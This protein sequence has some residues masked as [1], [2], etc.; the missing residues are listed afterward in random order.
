MDYPGES[1]ITTSQA[2]DRAV[3]S[4][5][6]LFLISAIGFSISALLAVLEALGHSIV[7]MFP[8]LPGFLLGEAIWGIDAGENAFEALMI[9]TNGAFYSICIFVVSAAFRL[10]RKI[11]RRTW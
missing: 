10:I 4:S 1:G 6:R 5:R 8:Q 9:V 7:W 11:R 3:G 2:A